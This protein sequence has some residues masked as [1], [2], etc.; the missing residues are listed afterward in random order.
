MSRK[1]L[2]GKKA[3]LVGKEEMVIEIKRLK[4]KNHTSGMDDE[5]SGRYSE[6]VRR[7]TN[8]THLRKKKSTPEDE[9]RKQREAEK[10]KELEAKYRRWNKGVAQIEERQEQIKEMERTLDEGFSRYADDK[11]MNE[12]LKEQLLED[13]PMAEYFK[14]KKHKVQM[15]TGIVYPTYNGSWMPNRF[16][17]PPGYRWDGV[18]RSNGFEGKIALEKNKRKANEELSYKTISE[19]TE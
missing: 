15:R 7:S 16:T 17:I 12:H 6:T 14:L 10:Q 1:T 3:G 8:F 18:D 11:A 5:T 13:D 4:E 2:E 9:A 19:L